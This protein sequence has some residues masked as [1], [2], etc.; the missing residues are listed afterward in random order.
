MYVQGISR[1]ILKKTGYPKDQSQEEK[2][3]DSEAN[4]LLKALDTGMTLYLN[5]DYAAALSSFENAKKI[6]LDMRSKSLTKS[7]AAQVAGEI[8]DL[9]SKMEV[10]LQDDN[11]ASA[12]KAEKLYEQRRELNELMIVLT[13][14]GVL[15]SFSFADVFKNRKEKT[16]NGDVCL[17]IVGTKNSAFKNAVKNVFQNNGYVISNDCSVKVTVFIQ[18]DR[19]PTDIEGLEKYSFGFSIK[20]KEILSGKQTLLFETNLT[21][22]GQN[23]DQALSLVINDFKR[24]LT[25]SIGDFSF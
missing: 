17:N 16:K 20:A 24:E 6:S 14:K 15:E 2:F 4:Q 5:K 3:Y 9:D 23:A 21:E 22:A 25:E 13:G 19:L 18:A 10:F 7:A 11:A 8:D 12:R 1:L